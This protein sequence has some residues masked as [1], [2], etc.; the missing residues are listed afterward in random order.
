MGRNYRNIRA[1]QLSD[2]LTVLIYE[3]SN[4]FPKDEA[5][6]LTSQLRRSAVS[7]PANI[8]EGANREHKK[9]YLH[10]LYIAR[11]SLAETEY[12]LHLSKRL[13]Y[14]NESEYGKID[15]LRIETASTLHGL[16]QAV[17]KETS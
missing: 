9:E 10:F 3:Y 6:G 14:T 11:G 15:K 17:K 16:I 13:G 8:A 7:V 1:W 12:Y 4:K 5:Y 2:D